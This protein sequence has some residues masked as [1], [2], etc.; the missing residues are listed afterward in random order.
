MKLWCT[1]APCIYLFILDSRINSDFD[2]FLLFFSFW[3]FLCAM[4]HVL[5]VTIEK[6]GRNGGP[7]VIGEGKKYVE[8]MRH[9][10]RNVRFKDGKARSQ[11]C[12]VCSW[13]MMSAEQKYKL[14][15]APPPPHSLIWTRAGDFVSL[16]TPSSTCQSKFREENFD[17]ILQTHTSTSWDTNWRN[18]NQRIW[19][20]YSVEN[21]QT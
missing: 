19:C 18:F 12:T 17:N 5:A 21:D 20:R 1:I 10:E 3:E 8:T 11:T 15:S 6:L 14:F 9:P 7:L 16:L 13:I 4:H 2:R